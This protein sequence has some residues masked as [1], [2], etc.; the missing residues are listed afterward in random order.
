MAERKRRAA[1]RATRR[2]SLLVL[3]NRAQ[4]SVPLTVTE[5]ALLR[6]HVEVELAESDELRRTVQGAQTAGQKAYDRIGAAEA[7]IVEAEED[8]A[9][10][11]AQAAADRQLA[12]DQAATIRSQL[13]RITAAEGTLARVR[14]ADTL[15]EALI[16]V[17][18]HDGLTPAAAAA[19]AAFLTAAD[20]PDAV[21][22]ERDREHAIALAVVER[23]ARLAEHAL[24]EIARA[25]TWPD[26]WA[27]LGAHA[28]Q[29]GAAR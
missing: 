15:G 16:A 1:E 5:A 4:R 23:R 29:A 22:A 21:Q 7:A 12:E 2:D 24:T 8:A 3:L 27:A 11:R 14:D 9:Q 17:H 25:R 6:A 10:A 28:E 19:H 26:V 18:E 13:A 20:R